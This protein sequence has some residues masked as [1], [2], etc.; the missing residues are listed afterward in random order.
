MVLGFVLQSWETHFRNRAYLYIISS[1]YS[2][3]V[4]STAA[5][6][7]YSHNLT[8]GCYEF[9]LQILLHSLKSGSQVSLNA[10]SLETARDIECG[11]ERRI[12]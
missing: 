3:I 10:S 7:I 12:Q 11:Q 4:L 9:S 8:L 2:I 1:G 6:D 5:V